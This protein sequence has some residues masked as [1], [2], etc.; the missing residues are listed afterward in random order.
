MAVNFT[1][2]G[3]SLS[4]VNNFLNPAANWTRC[5]WVKLGAVPT[6]GS[7][8]TLW[9]FGDASFASDYIW[10]GTSD[11]N[12]VE[13]E[14]LNNATTY[15][16]TTPTL[17][18]GVWYFLTVRYNSTTNVVELYYKSYG[19]ITFLAGAITVDLSLGT[20]GTDEFIGSDSIPTWSDMSFANERTWQQELTPTQINVE[21]TNNQ[22]Y[23][24]TAAVVANLLSQSNLGTSTNITDTVG[25]HNWTL[26]V[27]GAY[28][29]GPLVAKTNYGIGF[30]FNYSAILQSIGAPLLVRAEG[31]FKIFSLFTRINSSTTV[32]GFYS[33]IDWQFDFDYLLNGNPNTHVIIANPWID[34]GEGKANPL[35]APASVR[36][37]I[38]F[39]NLE[40]TGQTSSYDMCGAGAD[41]L[42]DGA[43]ELKI[44]NTV[45]FTTSNIRVED[46]PYPGD[47]LIKNI[48]YTIGPDNN[49]VDGVWVTNSDVSPTFTGIERVATSPYL[50]TY[51]DFNVGTITPWSEITVPGPAYNL[52]SGLNLTGTIT[53]GYTDAS[54][55]IASQES[56]PYPIHGS[57]YY[58]PNAQ[59]SNIFSSIST[60]GD[61]VVNKITVPSDV[62]DFDFTTVGLSVPTFTLADGGT[63]TFDPIVP[64]SGYSV[65]ETANSG[66]DT[67]YE[68]S[69]DPTN[70]D[71]TNITVAAGETVIVTVTN[72]KKGSLE[73]AKLSDVTNDTTIFTFTAVAPLNP[74]TF[75]LMS[76]D[77]VLFSNLSAGTYSVT[78]AAVTGYTINYLFSDA[79]TDNTAIVIASGED[80]TLVVQNEK[81]LYSG[82]YQVT[83][84]LRHDSY[85]DQNLLTVDLAIPNPFVIT[86]QAGDN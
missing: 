13:L 9:I 22:F 23:A 80:V 75:S 6:A 52:I 15:S 62:T 57:A 19:S 3:E 76:G 1:S 50:V 4:R 10:L 85:V 18:I 77:S 46:R 37:D 20:Y 58:A 55:S 14:I 16:T 68:V 5:C 21:A 59:I 47:P 72:T 31:I 69:N 64:G 83:S 33:V 30:S 63:Q 78:E 53:S 7:I 36:A 43:I 49:D 12:I 86:A 28:T 38:P 44:D 35:V 65:V 24:A 25:A 61:I 60:V 42:S 56:F 67:T 2:S 82:M 84:G 45:Y 34:W 81:Q 73:V 51:N 66:Y 8:R 17:T 27:G 26:N 40:I 29:L 70:N 41:Y 54:T 79:N 74:L 71:N 39:Y 48:K 32:G 11:D